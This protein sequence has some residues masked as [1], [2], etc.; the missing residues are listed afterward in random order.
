MKILHTEHNLHIEHDP[1]QDLAIGVIQ[2]AA[3]DYR[4]LTREL[5]LSVTAEEKEKIMNK[6]YSIRQFFLSDWFAIL[7]NSHSGE[8]IL[9]KLDEEVSEVG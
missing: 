5:L 1:Y 3:D 7:S 2:Q 4:S 9:K 8:M 6:I